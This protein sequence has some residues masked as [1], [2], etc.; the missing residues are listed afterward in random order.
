[1]LRAERNQLNPPLL[2]LPAELRNIVYD[3][4]L[5]TIILRH[6]KTSDQSKATITILSGLS[7]VCRQ[8]QPRHGWP[9]ESIPRSRSHL[10]VHVTITLS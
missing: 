6:E 4:V 10:L 7:P 5:I 1:M 2:R 3:L 9:S 8:I